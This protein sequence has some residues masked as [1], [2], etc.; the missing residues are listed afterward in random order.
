MKTSVLVTGANS[1]LS[2]TIKSL[3]GFSDQVEYIFKSK[4][5]LNICSKRDIETL[6]E[7]FNFDYCVNC[8]AY[9][10]VEN[11][12]NDFKTAIQINGNAVEFLAKKCREKGIILI[13]IS[14][15]YV[16]DGNSEIPYK[17]DHPTNPVNLYGW[18]KLIGEQAVAFNMEKFFIIRVSWLFSNFGRN[19]LK[20]IYEKA[21]LDQE[22][23]VVNTQFGSPTS[24]YCLSRFIHFL[25]I[26]GIEAFGIY[27]FSSLNY[28]N[29]YEFARYIGS[30]VE[31]Y[32]I[33]KIQAVNHYPT[34]AKRPDFSV[35]DLSKTN[36]IY[37]EIRNWEEAAEEVISL[38]KKQK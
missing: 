12:E 31:N 34:I 27:H 24:T 18:S 28:T 21:S 19:F 20:S 36:E 1:Q 25:I 35:L 38:H 16:F 7:E 6:L 29:W 10:D 33:E 4:D 8:A 11:A 37:P 30:H 32:D 14:T 22:L 2:R 15:D 13:Q 5:E 9:T 26:T 3:Y 17:T 23:K